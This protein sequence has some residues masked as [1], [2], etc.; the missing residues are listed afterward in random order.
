MS[1]QRHIAMSAIMQPT[2]AARS[3]INRNGIVELS[4]SMKVVG[5]LQ[6]ILLR[7]QGDKYEIEAG[8]R[9]FLAASML[10]WQEIEAKVLDDNEDAD[11]H[12]ERAHEN[13]IRENLTAVDE[14]RQ[15]HLLVHEKGRGIDD[16]ARLL[17]KSP[18]WVENRLDILGWP[19][20]IQKELHAGIINIAVGR[21]LARVKDAATRSRLLDA[22]IAYGATKKVVTQWVDDISVDKFLVESEINRDI[23][24][25]I[26]TAI[27]GVAMDCRICGVSHDMSRLKHIWLCPDCL[28]GIRELARE[29]RSEMERIA[30]LGET[31]TEKVGE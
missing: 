15:V 23:G 16:T 11:M 27:T 6:P 31:R 30:R 8:H 19:E 9:R 1:E 24:E 10:N 7:R 17:S 4:E 25:N 26:S 13:L 20:E 3:A 22:A 5:L 12:L 2:N 28:L 14:A 21:E 29:T 18:A